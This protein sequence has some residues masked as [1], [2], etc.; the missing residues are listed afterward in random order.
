M[1]LDFNGLPGCGKTTL[2]LYLKQKIEEEGKNA[3]LFQDYIDKHVNSNLNSLKFFLKGIVRLPIA[4]FLLFI[5]FFFSLPLKAPKKIYRC[6]LLILNYLLYKNCIKEHNNTVIIS[7]QC[8]IQE[9][10]SCYYDQSINH[11]KNLIMSLIKILD[12]NYFAINA[13]I[14]IDLV[15]QRL[16]QRENGQSRLDGLHNK[17]NIISTLRIQDMN[18]SFIRS[19]MKVN[20]INMIDINMEKPLNENTGVIMNW[21]NGGIDK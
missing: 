16:Q 5:R 8:I 3:L 19:C 17:N 15:I 2:S 7:E 10:V 12:D 20:N 4:H 1:F 18:I 21:I 14:S 13:H 6:Y 9:I 11:K